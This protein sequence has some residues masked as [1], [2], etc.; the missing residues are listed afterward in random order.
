[1]VVGESSTR[2]GGVRPVV[3]MADGTL[4]ELGTVQGY[5]NGKAVSVNNQDTIAGYNGGF[6]GNVPVRWTGATQ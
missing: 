5:S 6:N 2:S 4:V 3:W 1:M